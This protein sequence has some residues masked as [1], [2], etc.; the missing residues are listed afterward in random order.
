[1]NY[2]PKIRRYL[3]AN[4]AQMFDLLEALVVTQSSSFHKAGVDLVAHTI[5]A[6]LANT[7]V[8]FR[9]VNQ[10]QFGNHLIIQS[11]AVKTTG[12]PQVLLVGHMDT[13]FPHDTTFNWYKEDAHN[14]YGPGVIDMKGGLVAGLFALKALDAAD[15]LSQIPLTFICNSDEEI[16]SVSSA[17]LIREYAAQSAFAFVLECGGLNSEVVTGRKGNLSA[18]VDVT[19]QA[20]HAAFAG[21]DKRSSILELAHKTIAL[22]ALNDPDRG[23]TVNV[24]R[25]EGGI[26]PNTVAE[27]ASARIDVRFLTPEDGSAI[28][29]RLDKIISKTFL[30]GT[31]TTCEVMTRRP[32]MPDCKANND[33][34]KTVQTVAADLDQ[35]IA[36]EFR[37]G[38]SDAN[39]IAAENIPVIDGLGPIG[40]RDHSKDEYMIKASL[41]ERTILIACA[42][43]VC[44]DLQ[45]V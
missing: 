43:P 23:I 19:G 14:A 27:N 40:G 3:K 34:F 29:S 26:G 15:L 12:A 42:I 24:G 10:E 32:P 45:T 21:Q 13:V 35:T 5:E 11:P 30:P 1:M 44:Y 16:G 31:T 20:G 4:Q 2:I 37:F 25:I 9:T 33:L 41:L 17:D 18:K 38:V 7:N 36:P 8:T 22:E 39:L 28:E 6:F